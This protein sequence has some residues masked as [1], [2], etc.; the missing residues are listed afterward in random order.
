MDDGPRR[1]ETAAATIGSLS[2]ATLGTSVATG[3]LGEGSP[4]IR[5]MSA[6]PQVKVWNEL[7]GG[8]WAEHAGHF[9]LSLQPFGDAV[10]RRLDVGAHERV[11][12]IGCG[13]GATTVQLGGISSEVLGVDI[14]VPMLSLARRRAVD[15]GAT[16]VRFAE[17]DVQ[18]RPFADGAFEVAFSRFGVM[19]FTDPV[20]AFTH[21]GRS[22]ID[23]GRLG[24]VCFDVMERNPFIAE[25]VGAAA[26]HLTIPPLP[27]PDAPS[28]FSLAD[29]ERSTAILVASGFSD[30]RIESGPESVTLG[31]ADDLEGVA[32]RALEQNAMSGPAMSTASA[33]ERDAAVAATVDVLASHVT[34]GMVTMS[35]ATWIVTASASAIH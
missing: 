33:L 3:R 10:L 15:H 4:Y 12:D 22:L 13:T 34:E 28:P 17:V 24:F 19:F 32:R 30:V 6:N 11:L 9:D 29:P 20:R 8:A 18:E 26:A 25:P 21:I 27:A 16:N 31:R 1:S 14:S 5:T 23:G 2:V 7:V 35:S